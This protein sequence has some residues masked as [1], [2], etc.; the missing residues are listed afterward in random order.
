[1]MEERLADLD[2]LILRC[3]N[4]QARKYIAEAVACYRAAA[5]RSSIVATWIA[6][7]FDFIQKLH[8][9]ELSGDAN[10]KNKLAEFERIVREQDI[11]K[12]L[13]FERTALDEARDTYELISPS[14]HADL[15]RLL[16]DRNR[17][18][19]PSM[20]SFDE[21]YQPTAELTRFHLRNAVTYLL[22]HPPVQ[23]K[24]ALDRLGK[25]VASAYFPTNITD[26]TKAFKTGP[27]LRP[28]EALVR[29][30]VIVL[31]KKFLLDAA[32]TLDEEHRL[33]AAIGAV[34]EMHSDVSER[35]L[36]EK[37]NGA[38][39]GV[40]D[41]RLGS[42][43]RF[44]QSVPDTWQFL[45]DD[46]RKRI[47]IY[48]TAMPADDLPTCLAATFEI[49]DLREHGNVR[50]QNVTADEFASL[51]STKTV[52]PHGVIIERGVELYAASTSFADANSLGA[53]VISPLVPFLKLAHVERVF[54]VTMSN[55]QIRD[56][57]YS[58]VVLRSIRDAWKGTPEEFD[59]LFTRYGL[60]AKHPHLLHSVAQTEEVE[61]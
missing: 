55:S 44:L 43:V 18:A 24:S 2:E 39:R 17:C 42:T 61:S 5:F 38:M 51:V 52:E 40:S 45:E 36:G 41:E 28:R 16:E 13:E 60:H 20:N 26:A 10:A 29:N 35:A 19:H 33:S 27:L 21:V 57:K 22:Q 4:E 7:V 25:E 46:V 47:A 30:F 9:L 3:R 23:G 12:S 50:L 58:P 1:M 48:A 34:R 53:R 8:E 15:K 14:E 32:T 37:L 6:I 59:G 54:A 56:S 11:K 49:A 31:T